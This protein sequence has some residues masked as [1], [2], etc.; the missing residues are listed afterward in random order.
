[1]WGWRNNGTIQMTA[2]AC[3]FCSGIDDSMY[4]VRC[5]ACS[6]K[7]HIYCCSPPLA[8]VPR[9][10][11]KC[12]N[13]SEGRTQLAVNNNPTEGTTS[14]TD[15]VTK[16]VHGDTN[17]RKIKKR[18]RRRTEFVCLRTTELEDLIEK[19]NEHK[20]TFKLKSN[21][22]GSRRNS[23][24][25]SLAS[26]NSNDTPIDGKCSI[27]LKSS[28]AS[29][30][31]SRRFQNEL[32]YQDWNPGSM[33]QFNPLCF[34][35]KKLRLAKSGI[36]SMGVYAL[37][38]IKVNDFVIEYTGELVRPSVAEMRESK[39]EKMNIGGSYLFRIDDELVIDAT[40]TGNLARF[41]NHS[42]DPNCFTKVITV[43]QSKRIVI[44]AKRDIMIGEELAYDYKF[45]IESDE[46]KVLCRC[47]ASKCRKYLN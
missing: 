2:D 33:L 7:Y 26:T 28:R 37:D 11:W 18:K 3:S 27:D 8:R 38:A 47:G 14:D 41:I 15:E 13:C 6:S 19:R 30:L 45:P 40:F 12:T 43:D 22:S 9:L 10:L 1:L 42:C 34:R 21:S 23:L 32:S 17:K 46:D 44:Y 36:H 29:R 39:Y 16:K 25:S 31:E 20:E 5:S 35:Q 4:L 24:A